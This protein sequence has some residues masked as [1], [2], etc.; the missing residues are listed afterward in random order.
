VLPHHHGAQ[1]TGNL[2]ANMPNTKS[3]ATRSIEQHQGLL[4]R[5]TRVC[6]GF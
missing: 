4:S 6:R 5:E 2:K 3:G 1:R